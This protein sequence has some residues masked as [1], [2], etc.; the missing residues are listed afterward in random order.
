MTLKDA[1]QQVLDARRANEDIFVWPTVA[2]TLNY[3]HEEV[4]EWARYVQRADAPA[5]ARNGGLDAEGEHMEAGQALMMMLTLCLQRG[6]DPDKALALACE[7]IA[8]TAAK[9]RAAQ[10]AP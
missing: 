6:L 5:H 7:K 3:I 4:S 1:M 8:V 10:A 2:W 9:Q